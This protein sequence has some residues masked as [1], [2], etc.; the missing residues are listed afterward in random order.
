M[1]G[2]KVYR[3][4][5]AVAADLAETGVPRTGFNG[6]D[7][8]P[9]RTIDD[10]LERLAPV[11]ARRRL[12]VLPRVLERTTGD[13][14]GRD[15]AL[16]VNVGLRVAFDLVSV[17]DGSKHTVEAFG[18]ALDEGDKG[19]AKAMTAAYK[20]AMFQTFCIPVSGLEDVDAASP[21]LGRDV[22]AEPVQGWEQWCR[23]IAQ[24]IG[25][26]ESLD[27]VDRVHTT[28]RI[29]LR[30][31]SRERPDLYAGLGIT[32]AERRRVLAERA[33]AKASPGGASEDLVGAGATDSA[34]IEAVE[35]EA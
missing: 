31:L 10:L 22:E 17:A 26:C 25:I 18:E 28:Q 21:K 30:S 15:G 29:L 6:R 9:Y 23:D 7:Q 20:S 4:I 35:A 12:C 32:V 19:T 11:L 34:P 8:Y 3:A 13:R 33:L 5:H 27:A 16:L 2:G 24:T 1:T 14:R